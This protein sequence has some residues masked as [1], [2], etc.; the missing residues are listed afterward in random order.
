MS[1]DATLSK[2]KRIEDK[3]YRMILFIVPPPRMNP[4]TPVC[5]DLAISYQ[6]KKYS[7]LYETK[8]QRDYY[9]I[10]IMYS[11]DRNRKCDKRDE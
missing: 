1:K 11:V 2:Y 10:Q 5:E 4:V 6:Y 3:L 8:T 9:G 7:I